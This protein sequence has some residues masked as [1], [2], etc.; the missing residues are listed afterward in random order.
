MRLIESADHAV[1]RVRQVAGLSV[2]KCK[3]SDPQDPVRTNWTILVMSQFL[4]WIC[5]SPQ[6]QGHVIAS[7]LSIKQV[8]AFGTSRRCE[9]LQPCVSAAAAHRLLPLVGFHA[10]PYHQPPLHLGFGPL[11]LPY[12]RTYYNCVLV[13]S[14]SFTSCAL[15]WLLG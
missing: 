8:S 7:S 6:E 11:P 3:M 14:R 5:D 2:T 10:R 1:I 9:S 4:R 15:D 13:R 12:V